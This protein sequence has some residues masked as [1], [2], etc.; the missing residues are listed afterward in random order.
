VQSGRE[1]EVA[2]PELKTV[3]RSWAGVGRRGA[4]AS[5]REQVQS[6]KDFEVA[7][8]ELQNQSAGVGAELE[9][10]DWSGDWQSWCGWEGGGVRLE[11]EGA[12]KE[13]QRV[14][15]S[16]LGG[17]GAERERARGGWTR[18]E[19]SRQE[20]GWSWKERSR[21]EL[22]GAGAELEWL[23]GGWVRAA[24][25]VGRS[26]GRAGRQGLKRELTKLVRV[27]RRWRA[28]GVGGGWSR[29][30][31]VRPLQ[32]NFRRKKSRDRPVGWGAGLKARRETAPHLPW[33]RLRAS[34]G[35]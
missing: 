9:G 6:W 30:E 31:S 25:P 10:R 2:G 28:T 22:K 16:R 1:L 26:W 21:S 23:R 24:K 15:G 35:W 4:A 17:T 29:R 18:T 13:P 3:G 19:N 33:R 8:S 34:P 11:W 32:V 27:G 5:W 14:G 12:G 7:G 20:L